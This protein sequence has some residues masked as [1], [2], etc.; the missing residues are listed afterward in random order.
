MLSGDHIS[1]SSQQVETPATL[2][3]LAQRVCDALHASDRDRCN[4]LHHDLDAGDALIAAQ[5]QVVAPGWKRWLKSNCFLSVRT[6]MLYMQLAR[7]REE[8]EAEIGRVGDLSL[9]AA[10]RLISKPADKPDKPKRPDPHKAADAELTKWLAAMGMNKF[11]RIMPPDW[12]PQLARRVA[13]LNAKDGETNV[14]LTSALRTALSHLAVADAPETSK[15]VAQSQEL[16]AL[17]ALRG[18]TRI[19][20]EFHELTITIQS[21]ERPRRRRCAA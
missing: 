8:I 9:R 6:A 15:P 19:H 3:E 4:A 12:R 7:H 20:A 5:R 11:L 16:A 13:G 18:I 14:T 2:A 10:V 17:N 1:L 21:D